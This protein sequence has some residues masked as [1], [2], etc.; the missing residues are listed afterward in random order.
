MGI[1]PCVVQAGL[2]PE[3]SCHSFWGSEMLL[4]CPGSSLF[5]LEARTVWK[6]Q[7]NPFFGNLNYFELEFI[8]RPL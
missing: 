5:S 8:Q 4:S 3:C 7:H 6:Y 1:V 2:A